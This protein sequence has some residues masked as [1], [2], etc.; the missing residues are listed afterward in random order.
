MGKYVDRQ[1][2][3]E[4]VQKANKRRKGHVTSLDTRQW[5]FPPHPPK[6]YHRFPPEQPVTDWRTRGPPGCRTANPTR[7]AGHGAQH[8][9][10][11][12]SLTG[13]YKVKRTLTVLPSNSVP[14]YLPK[15]NQT[16]V[17]TGTFSATLF[18][19]ATPWK[20]PKYPSAGEWIRKLSYIRTI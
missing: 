8:V 19:T 11:E 12:N 9:T 15:R 3:E 7:S 6:G 13:S 5:K 14:R 18:L 16:D 20:Q 10:L 4:D 2:T 1:F 17:Y